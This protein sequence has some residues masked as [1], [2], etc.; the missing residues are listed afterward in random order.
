MPAVTSRL[1]GSLAGLAMA[2][3][4]GTAA[5]SQSSAPVVKIDSGELQGG[6]ADGVVSFKGIPFAAPPVGALR[7]RPP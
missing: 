1:F 4:V 2:M 5:V 6:V 7:W 3:G